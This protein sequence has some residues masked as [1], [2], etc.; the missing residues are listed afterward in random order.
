MAELDSGFEED[1]K[2]RFPDLWHLA[3]MFPELHNLMVT[4][5]NEEWEPARFDS[6]LT[7]TWFWQ[8]RSAEKR[9]W[10]IE[11]QRDPGTA[12]RRREQRK[13]TITARASAYGIRLDPETLDSLVEL[14]LGWGYS[15]QEITNAILA[16][17]EGTEIG[18]GDITAQ[19]D[20]IVALGR[21]YLMA[22]SSY[23]AEQMAIKIERGELTVDG[24]R[25]RFS[26]QARA[27]F[28]QFAAQLSDGMSIADATSSIRSHVGNL[29]GMSADQ[30]DFNE[31]RWT[32]LIDH[33]DESGNRRM[34]TRAEA[35]RWARGT[36]TE[37]RNTDEAHQLVAGVVS[38]V[39]KSMGRLA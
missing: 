25:K 28:P 35:G 6:E 16:Q 10:D 21:D 2:T 36:Q 31:D 13:T 38:G 3:Q 22:V 19:A 33:V 12:N 14:S 27:A 37:Y 32:D 30:I 5:L 15:D 4:A 18:F 26:D 7:Q 9:N 39:A 17:G 34:M 29:L 1:L 8:S 20:D 24:I 23:D 11:S